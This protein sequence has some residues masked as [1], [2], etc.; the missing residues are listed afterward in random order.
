MAAEGVKHKIVVVED[1]GL[2]AADLAARLKT[3]GYA[4]PGTADSAH[5]ALQLIRKT[6]PDLVLM[7]IRL[8]GSVD[9][10]EIAD[11]VRQ[12]LDIPGVFLTAYEDRGTLE[13]A[14]RSQAFGY[15]KKP[16]A[17]ASLKGSIEMAIAKH[18]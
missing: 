9:G 1:E 17:A 11:Q 15:I 10:I 14:G 16:I 6:S 7:D 2:I 4:V 18:R 8:K 5:K 12:Q 13:R 3:A